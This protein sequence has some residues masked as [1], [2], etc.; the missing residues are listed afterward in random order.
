MLGA[1]YLN[2]N[3]V[4]EAIQTLEKAQ[5]MKPGQSSIV[6]ALGKAYFK[7]GVAALSSKQYEP[8]IQA[9]SKSRDHDPKNAYVFYNLAEAYLFLKQYPNAEKALNQAAEFMPKSL[10]LYAR[11]GLVY[12]KQNKWDL[13]LNAYK[14][15]DEISP[16][17]QLKDSIARMTE[18]KK[19]K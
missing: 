15:A 5:S 3:R 2:L 18:N 12:E 16:S 17:K 10:E 19:K 4:D 9:L 13:A 1:C 8:A 6:E 7:K 14:K 11:M